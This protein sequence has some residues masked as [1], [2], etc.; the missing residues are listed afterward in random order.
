MRRRAAAGLGLAQLL[1]LSLWGQTTQSAATSSRPAADDLPAAVRDALRGAQDFALHF[2]Q[3][4]F[5][6][7][8]EFT[9]TTTT[10]H[11]GVETAGADAALV[12]DDWRV[13]LERPASLRGQRI[14][15]AGIVGRNSRWRPG[16][17]VGDWAMPDEV[18]QLELHRD[19]QPLAI[20]VIVPGQAHAELPLGAAVQVTGRFVLVRQY[21]SA[22]KRLQQAALLTAHA[23]Q[24]VT[25][26]DAPPPRAG[27][28]QRT[29]D[30][31]WVLAAV[32]GG[33]A[34]A[35]VALRRV[36][37]RP[38]DARGARDLRARHAAPFSVADDYAVWQQ[39][40]QAAP[41]DETPRGSG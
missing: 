22:S 16:G 33:L 41:D 1:A 12:V 24:V 38:A 40:A 25:L 30:P 32:V 37:A 7:L 10:A 27:N 31:R 26:R 29:S 15:L 3:P 35:L 36:A 18:T 17:A 11:D 5:Y 23:S 21:Y 19:G 13:F 28:A 34:I 39:V 4:A 8:L 14:S 20:T 6:G 9:W 2:D